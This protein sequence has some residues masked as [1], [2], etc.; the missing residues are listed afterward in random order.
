MP[1]E[2]NENG[3][4]FLYPENW[5]LEKHPA[6]D[7]LVCALTLEA[8]SGALWTLNVEEGLRDT[9]E[10]AESVRKTLCEEY[11]ETEAEPYQGKWGDLESQGFELHFYVIEM[12]AR[13][14]IECVQFKNRTYLVMTQA[15]VRDYDELAPVFEA[16]CASLVGKEAEA[17]ESSSS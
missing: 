14:L 3:V 5:R 6:L 13:A 2:F 15:E 10:V 9:V 17:D 11:D 16:L 7:G 4:R 12:V 1:K 8:P